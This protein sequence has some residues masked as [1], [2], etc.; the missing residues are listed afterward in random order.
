MQVTVYSTPNCVQCMTTKR[1][2]D[3]LGI[4]YESVD[5]SERPDL[6]DE[7]REKGYTTAP[8]VTT[9]I[10]IWSG[11]RYEKIMSLAQHLNLEKVHENWN[12]IRQHT[13]NRAD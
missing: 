7:F 5:L 4:R 12:D 10:K 3:R 2:M 9:D 11:Y 1:H 13:K 8:I 6:V